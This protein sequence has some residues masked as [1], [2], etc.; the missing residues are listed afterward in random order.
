[1]PFD[2]EL[3]SDCNMCDGEYENSPA[4][5]DLA[6]GVYTNGWPG[7]YTVTWDLHAGDS[8]GDDWVA[9]FMMKNGAMIER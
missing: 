9:I 4:N 6:S 5:F 3:Y 1:M 2:K 7:T 8:S